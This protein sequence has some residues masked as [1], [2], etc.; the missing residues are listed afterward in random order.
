MRHTLPPI[1]LLRAFEACAR[2]LS[3]SRAAEELHLTQSAV[4]RQVAALET[5]LDLKLF[6]RVR[7]RLAPTLAGT[8]YAPR[9]CTLQF[10]TAMRLGPAL[11]ASG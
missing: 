10:G 4:S 7:R 1:D 2:H 6:H 5:L 11:A 8:A 9:M 3:V